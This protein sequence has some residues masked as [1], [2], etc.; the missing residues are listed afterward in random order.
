ML[1]VDIDS[2]IQVNLNLFSLKFCSDFVYSDVKLTAILGL[3]YVQ[4]KLIK[5]NQFPLRIGK[6]NMHKKG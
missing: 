4:T 5:V 1:H 3:N 6:T 2:I